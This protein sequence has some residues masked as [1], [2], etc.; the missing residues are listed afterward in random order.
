[1]IC[2][3]CYARACETYG[4]CAGCQADRLLPGIGPEGQRWCTDC[5]G[6][7]DFTCSRCGQEGWNHYRGVCGR[8]VLKDRLMLAL[9]DGTGR[10]R[11][12]LVA[13][14]DLITSMERPRAGILWL[15]RPAAPA[16][17]RAIARAEV[18]LTHEGIA[19]PSPLRSTIYVR[20][21]L[22]RA[23]VLPPVD[24][25]LFLFEQW[26]PGW[27]DQ[28]PV[29]DHRKLLHTY[30]SWR[31]LPHLREI[32]STQPVGH[33]RHQMARRRLRVAAG[34]LHGLSSHDLALAD[35]TQTLLDDWFAHAT[36]ADKANLRHFL[37]W[38][39][40]TKRMP[41]L[42]LPPTRST[43]PTPITHQQRLAWIRRIHHGD[44][45]ELA[46]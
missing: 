44:D 31:V 25:F 43:P 18:P 42:R 34:F 21:L 17:L 7:G 14:F 23:G 24:R 16:I 15:S 39:R 35:C 46:E 19:T 40:D 12:E 4:V 6:L 27:L 9:D 37:R 11:P 28:L 45:M 41:R 33:Y 29:Q 5:A 20:D 22:V 38:A 2:S 1:L 30:A 36:E 13:L 10:V 8:C 32:A 3:A 26:L